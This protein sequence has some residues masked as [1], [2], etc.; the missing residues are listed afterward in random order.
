MWL[1]KKSLKMYFK[2]TLKILH[3]IP[4]LNFVVHGVKFGVFGNYLHLWLRQN[5]LRDI[6]FTKYTPIKYKAY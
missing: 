5:Q 3:Y 2:Y 4:K 1:G 6:F